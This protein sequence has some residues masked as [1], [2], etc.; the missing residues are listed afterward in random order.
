MVTAQVLTN[1]ANI[2]LVDDTPDNL[3]VL[4]KI[5]ESEGFKIRKTTSGKWALQAAQ[6][7]P[8]DLILLDVS[9]PEMDGYEVCQQLKADPATASIPVIF[10]SALDQIADKIRAFEKGGIDYITKPFQDQEVLAR[11]KNQL[12]IQQQRK[13]LT[14]QNQRLEEEI[15][16][17]RLAEEQV[18]QLN[19]VLEEQ[20]LERTAQLQRSLEFESLLKR[21]T[22]KV[23]DSLDESQ[24]LQTAV[25]ALAEGLDVDCCDTGIYSADH[26]TSTIA[27]EFTKSLESAQGKVISLTDNPNAAVYQQLF[28]GQCS[29]FNFIDSCPSRP[30]QINTALVCPI[31]DD[32]EVLGDLWLF[33]QP[34]AC[35]TDLEIRLVQQVANQC[36]I[37][38]R[39]ARLYRSAQM[40]VEEL[41]RL[42]RLKDDFLSTISHELRTPMSTIKMALQMLEVILKPLGVLEPETGSATQYFHILNDECRRE[43]SLLSDLLD[44]SHLDAEV[45]PLLSTEVEL[46]AWIPHIAEPLLQ[47]FRK[48]SQTL[49]FHLSTSLPPIETDLS[50]L[51]KILTELLNNAC[52]YTPSGEMIIVSAHYENDQENQAIQ[53]EGVS[54]APFS[55]HILLRVSNA[56]VE[57]PNH[58]FSRIFEKFY[59]I[60]NNDPWKHDGIGLGLALVKKRVKRLGGD[61]DVSSGAN[62]THFTLKLPLNR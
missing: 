9:M 42:N 27:Y 38:L 24:I 62:Q 25:Q 57:I 30:G 16:H 51:E 7:A 19:T 18:Q 48:Q 59:R 5:L 34:Q 8:P 49:Q 20:V 32:H 6:I 1:L 47:R 39:Q 35:F 31:F 22:D 15:Q 33:R 11:V 56:G 43:I 14:A 28:Q 4:A 26:T 29:Q 46:G 13:Q 55:P 45:E 37:A 60:P 52:K 3:R 50:T 54:L 53:R 21:I 41:E 36:A 12:M 23:R 44:L 17:R 61:I 58:E 40:Q 2:L 10:I